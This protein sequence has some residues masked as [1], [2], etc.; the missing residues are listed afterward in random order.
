M[1]ALCKVANM[2]FGLDNDLFYIDPENE[3]MKIAYPDALFDRSI[4][5][6]RAMLTSAL[7][8]SIGHNQDTG[9]VDYGKI[10]GICFL[11]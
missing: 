6:G 5:D 1:D 4:T 8:L 11:P 10:R 7:T 3:E 9:D 2:D